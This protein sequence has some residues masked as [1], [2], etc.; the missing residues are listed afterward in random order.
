MTAPLTELPG[1]GLVTVIALA[2]VVESAFLVGVAVP[3]TAIALAAGVA[4]HVGTVSLPVAVTATALGT[5]TGGQLAYQLGCRRRHLG[6]PFA[7]MHRLT[8]GAWPLLRRN[9]HR[10]A[11]PTILAAQW[12]AGGRLLSPRAAGWSGVRRPRFTFAHTTSATAWAA[13][14]TVTG[15]AASA[16]T[17]D[18]LALTLAIAAGAAVTLGAVVLHRVHHGPTTG[19]APALC[20]PVVSLPAVSRPTAPHSVGAR[21]GGPGEG[22][23]CRS[24]DSGHGEDGQERRRE[25]VGGTGE[26]DRRGH[27]DAERAGELLGVVDQP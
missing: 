21:P 4:A 6:T 2:L 22:R 19:P 23:R 16:A 24:R 18:H 20:P 8:A 5:V 1:P 12:L 15:D 9:M 7:G 17:R 26:V 14:L 25:L 27:G 3:G 10:R 13:T 11:V